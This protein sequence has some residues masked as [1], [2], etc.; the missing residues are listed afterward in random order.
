MQVIFRASIMMMYEAIS[1]K[2]MTKND[3]Q[4]GPMI[5]IFM[6]NTQQLKLVKFMN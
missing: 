6:Y 3:R 4:M 1:S 5:H 2:I